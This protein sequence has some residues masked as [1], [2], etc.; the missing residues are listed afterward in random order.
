MAWFSWKE[1]VNREDLALIESRS[2]VVGSG[3]RSGPQIT[4]RHAQR[5]MP[6]HS[7]SP[8]FMIPSSQKTRANFK[9]VLP[10]M[11]IE[12][13][14]IASRWVKTTYDRNCLVWRATQD[15]QLKHLFCHFRIIRVVFLHYSLN[16]KINFNFDLLRRLEE[17]D[18]Y[19]S[20]FP[21]LFNNIVVLLRHC[22]CRHRSL[23]RYSF[24]HFSFSE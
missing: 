21:E 11:L 9:T 19:S 20:L 4:T 2:S 6:L 13:S 8:I 5:G 18:T 7:R 14:W 17:E 22:Y 3:P 15:L 16:D 24:E 12:S 23:L 1:T 10:A